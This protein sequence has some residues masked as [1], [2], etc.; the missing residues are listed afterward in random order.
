MSDPTVPALLVRDATPDDAA[1]CARIYAPYVTDTAITFESVAPTADE[2]G[3]RIAEAQV[4]HAWMTLELDHTTVGY[5]YAGPFSGRDAYRWAA[6]V[7]VYLDS[8]HRG[9]GGGRALYGALLPRLAD[10]GFRIAAACMTLPN[11]A[12]LGLH[13]A[14]GFERV[15]TFADIGWKL[16]RWHSTAWLQ[17]RLAPAAEGEPADLT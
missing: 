2:M 11:D 6:E 8:A 7:S 17:K 5:A 10:R 1:A 14:L 4:S 13:E 9:R 15:A 3:R 16:G 12:S